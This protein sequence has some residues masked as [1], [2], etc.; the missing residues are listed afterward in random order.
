MI[1]QA[2]TEVRDALKSVGIHAHADPKR[3]AIPGAWLNAT[4]IK[5]DTLDGGLAVRIDVHLVVRDQHA[6]AALA[7]LET[8]LA[9]ALDVL[10]PDGTILTS[11]VLQTDRY[12]LPCFVLPV[13]IPTERKV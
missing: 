3:V 9:A 2:I 1:T 5:Q 13:L 11:E 6:T 4:E 7:D 8:L 10:E 12:A